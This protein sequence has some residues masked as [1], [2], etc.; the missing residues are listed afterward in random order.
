MYYSISATDCDA[1]IDIVF[2]Y[3]AYDLVSGIRC[4]NALS[5]W[6]DTISLLWDM[7]LHI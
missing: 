3:N 2:H 5:F 6:E 1:S 4:E 7:G